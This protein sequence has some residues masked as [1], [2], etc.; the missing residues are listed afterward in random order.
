MKNKKVIGV[1]G[2]L[3]LVAAVGIGATL[4]YFTDYDSKENVVVMG[5]VDIELEEPNFAGNE[6]GKIENVAPNELIV[7][8]PTITVKAD[9]KDAYI[10][11]KVT[12]AWEEGGLLDQGDLEEMKDNITW[13]P[14]WIESP[15]DGEENVW[16]YQDLVESSDKDQ[17][18]VLFDMVMIP[19]WGNEVAGKTLKITVEA[20]AIQ[21]DNF[22][23]QRSSDNL[24]D[25]PRMLM[26]QDGGPLQFRIMTGNAKL[27]PEAIVGWYGITPEEYTLSQ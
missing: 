21:A 5:K 12:Y 2:S 4:A 17:E 1:I 19:N 24:T 25:S 7:K 13:Q 10:R 27:Y 26:E 22:N 14:G 18:F 9:S 16:Y 11:A 15:L 3:A 6:E 8:D 23:P 20:A